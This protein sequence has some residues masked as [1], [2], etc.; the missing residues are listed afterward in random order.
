LTYIENADNCL[1]Y[2]NSVAVINKVRLSKWVW[3]FRSSDYSVKT[4]PTPS[5]HL[6]SLFIWQPNKI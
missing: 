1:L 5:D 6:F 4:K 2:N 3:W